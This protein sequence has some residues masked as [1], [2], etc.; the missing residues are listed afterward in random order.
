MVLQSAVHLKILSCYLQ[1]SSP[2]WNTKCLNPQHSAI[3]QRYKHHSY[4]LP[5]SLIFSDLFKRETRLLLQR[6]F[7]VK[8]TMS[9]LNQKPTATNRILVSIKGY[10][11]RLRGSQVLIL[12]VKKIIFWQRM[13]NL[14]VSN[15]GIRYKRPQANSHNLKWLHFIQIP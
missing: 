10:W 1:I 11:P 5:F 6:E 8:L 9:N 3:F 4:S 13:Q 12:N 14:V 15:E 7:L 2:E